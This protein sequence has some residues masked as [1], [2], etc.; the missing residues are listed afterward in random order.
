MSVIVTV[1]L[2]VKPESVD[3][4]IKW[5]DKNLADTRAFEGFQHLDICQNEEDPT[6]FVFYEMWETK[7]HYEKYLAWRQE[8]SIAGL[9][10]TLAGDIDI[11]FYN[12]VDV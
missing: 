3:A 11:Q 7:A 5:L 9:A 6:K 8:G 4:A 12:R 1:N 2:Q 10:E